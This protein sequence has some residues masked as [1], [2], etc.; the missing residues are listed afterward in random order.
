MCV[1]LDMIQPGAQ[2]HSPALV[3]YLV[4]DGQLFSVFTSTSPART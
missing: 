4:S 3:T 1:S 2:Q